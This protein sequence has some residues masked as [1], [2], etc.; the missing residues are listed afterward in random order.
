MTDKVRIVLVATSHPG[1]IG[2]AA[3]ALKTMNLDQLWLVD[4]A[5]YPSMEAFS[6]AS[7]AVDVLDKARVVGSLEE[8]LAGCGLVIG[9]S[10]RPR[11]VSA[12]LLTPRDTAERVSALSDDAEAAIV[13]GRERTGL[14]NAELDQCQFQMNIPANPE[15]CSLNLAAAVQLM[16]YELNL[17]A[18]ASV[19][20]PTR[21]SP[22]ATADE[23][24]RFYAALETLLERVEFFDPQNPKHLMRRL[25]R[26]FGRA[27]PDRNEY[28]ILRGIIAAV[29][30]QLPEKS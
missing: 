14:T 23:M 21:K 18:G 16:A 22:Q 2:A 29:E 12:P 27:E 4:P 7:G 11:T 20:A 30:K 24:E 28:N 17:A 13:F 5:D 8:A 26:L 1:N 15:Y 25:R 19:Q 9:T 3:R 6:R 10:A